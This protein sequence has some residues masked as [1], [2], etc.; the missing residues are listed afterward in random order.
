VKRRIWRAAAALGAVPLVLVGMTAPAAH[1]SSGADQ[2]A[3]QYYDSGLAPTPYM[4]WNPYYGLGASSESQIKSVTDFLASSGLSGSGYNIVWEDGGWTADTPR[5]SSGAL[6]AN[7]SLFPSG[8]PSLV[9]Y[10]HSKGL[11]AG[12]YT[13]AGD[14]IKGTCG[15]GSRGHYDQDAKQFANWGFD[16]VKV[17]FLCG[18]SENLDPAQAFKAMSNAVWNSGRPM[19]LNL[20]NP[21]TNDWGLPHTPAQDATNNYAWGPTTGDSWRTGTDIAFGNPT[22]GSWQNVL[23]NADANAYHAEAQGIGHYNDPDY[24]IPMRKL[25][26]GSLEMTEEESTSQLVLWAEMASPLIIGSDPRTLPQSMI[27]T[28]RNPEI[29]G[30]DQDPLDIQGVRVASNSTGDVYSKA[31]QGSGN[32]AVVLLNRAGQ[33]AQLTVN[34][35]DAGL[36]G[37]V[38]VRDLRVRQDLG[39][40]TGSY[41]VTVPAHGTAFLKLSGTDAAPGVSLGTASSASP[42]LVRDGTQLS[43]FIRGSDGSLQQETGNTSG[44]WSSTV[45]NLGGPTNDQILGQPAAYGSAGGRIDLFVRG[46]DNAVYT[47]MFS[48]GGWGDF[49]SLGGTVTDAPTVAFTA[50]DNWTATARG[51]DGLIWTRDAGSGWTSIGAPNGL[52]TY[53]RPSAAVDSAGRIHVA[54]RTSD[55]S[56]WERVR[57]ASGSWGS[58]QSLGGVVGG[59]PTLV[60]VGSSVYAF[61]LAGD[62]TG[63]QNSYDAG[64]NSWSGWFTRGE[65]ASGTY[66]GAL[67][68]TWAADGHVLIV[69]RGVNGLVHQSSL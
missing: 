19:L 20:C 45:V 5:D 11:R 9:N 54:V 46:T 23:R 68:A 60:T 35:A 13:D 50:P 21:L 43:A 51:L 1:A 53:G 17:D 58:W 62:Y 10:I 34:F 31:L 48:G 59:S 40:R 36:T 44:Q 16:A 66:N 2:G 6:V 29:I 26:D 49:Q 42:A 22:A 32:R 33:A 47:R 25:P 56:V 39:T 4:G 30:V 41:S 52:P 27:D 15:L 57:S 12:I 38:S 55:D 65:F 28:L 7:P 63:W 37:S 69:Y 64:S 8:M 14:Y 67:G 18:I 3:P 24:L 61:A